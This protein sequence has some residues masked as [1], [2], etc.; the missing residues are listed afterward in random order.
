[1]LTIKLRDYQEKA[2]NLALD[3]LSRYG[4]YGLFLEQ[5]TGK[6]LTAL[7]TLKERGI[8]NLLIICPKRALPV[9][10]AEIKRVEGWTPK[11]TLLNFEQVWRKEPELLKAKFDG[12]IVDESHRIKERGS[13]QSKSCWKLAKEIPNRLVLTGT[14]V[15]NGLEDLYSQ[16]KVINPKLWP[17][18][19]LFEDRFLVMEKMD[20]PGRPMFYKIVGYINTHEID[21][22]LLDHSYRITRA[23]IETPKPLKIRKHYLELGESSKQHYKE[24]EKKLIT[25]VNDKEV[26]TPLVLTQALRLHQLCGGFL[27]TDDGEKFQVGTEKLDKLKNLLEEYRDEKVVVVARYLSEIDSISDLGKSLG[28]DTREIS[29][30]AQFDPIARPQLTILQPQSGL[31]I[32]LSYSSKLIIFSQDYSFLNYSQ[33]KDRIIKLGGESPTYHFLLVKDSMDTVI[34]GTV[35][36]KKK[37]SQKLMSIY[38]A[39]TL[40]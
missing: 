6:T 34:Y 40:R 30:R 26:T 5:R 12:M 29:G 18:W 2:K 10:T 33:F 13:K 22:A 15:G 8:K 21:K 19:K 39:P 20:L 16:F 23:E 7:F 25:L 31:A 1:M 9:W 38:R 24:L 27:T 4:G 37:L 35:V 36:E 17:T 3:G 14:P 28:M 11:V 32:D